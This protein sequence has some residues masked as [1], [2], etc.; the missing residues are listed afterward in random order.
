V[1]DDFEHPAA[2]PPAGEQIHMPAPSVLPLINAAGL[3]FAIISITLS[4]WLVG[5]G[6]LVFIVTAIKWIGDTRRDIADLPLEHGEH[7]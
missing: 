4:W 3:A 1:S 2:A 5:F 6:V 7:H